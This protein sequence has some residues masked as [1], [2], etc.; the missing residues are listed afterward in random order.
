MA[1]KLA[2]FV[3]I[4][5]Y[6]PSSVRRTFEI[7]RVPIVSSFSLS[8]VFSTTM[9]SSRWDP[10]TNLSGDVNF[11]KIRNIILDTTSC[12]TQLHNSIHGT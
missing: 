9:R 4:H 6:R 12:A 2:S 8:L 7:I 3:A 11:L 1:Q 10:M 5:S